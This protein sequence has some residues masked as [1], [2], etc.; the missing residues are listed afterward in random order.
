MSD[1]RELEIRLQ[2]LDEAQEYL[3]TLEAALLGVAHSQ[4]DTEKINGA[5]RAAHSIK[6]GAGMMGYS[7]LN[8]LAHRLEDS[9]KVLKIQKQ[10]LEI[11]PELEQLLLS[12]V[13]CLN[14]VIGLNR[15]Q[16]PVEQAWLENQ[17]EPIFEQLHQRLGDPQEEDAAS[18]LSPEEG[19]DI[20]PML[21]ETEVEGCLQ[22]LEAI[23]ADPQQPCLN[24]E[25]LILAQELQGLGEMLQISAFTAL[26]QSVT[27]QLE[28][29]PEHYGIIAQQAVAAWRQSQALV[30]TGQ[31]GLL[32]VSIA[33]FDASPEL[34]AAEVPLADIA[35]TDVTAD[36]I[37]TWPTTAPIEPPVTAADAAD[38]DFQLSSQATELPD[39][40]VAA[41]VISDASFSIDDEVATPPAQSGRPLEVKPDSSPPE[42]EEQDTNVRVSVKRLNA[43]NDLMGELTIERNSLT[44]NVSR[45]RGLIDKLKQRVQTLDQANSQLRSAYDQ[46][47][48]G[49]RLVEPKRLL[50]AAD[51]Q[52]QPLT[53]AATQQPNGHG[54]TFDTLEMDRYG[55][56][57][58]LSQEMME[59]IVQI[60][61]VTSD[62][63]LELEETEQ[64]GRKFNKTGKQLQ[65]G[66]TQV[67]MRPLSDILERFPRALRDLCLEHNKEVELKVV[68][69]N[70]LVDRNILEN[71]A[72]PLMHLLRNAFDHGLEDPNTRMT[73][74]KSRQGL[75]EIRA[76][77]RQNRTLITVK[78]DGRG[79][80]LDKVRRRAEQMGLDAELL[81]AASHQELLS[82]IFEPGFS[83][84]TEVTDL[85]GRGVG[86]DVVRNNLKQMRGEITVDTEPGQGTTFTLSVPFT[87][88]VAR[89]LLAESRNM[90]LAIPTD[91]MEEILLLPPEA[92]MST[93]QHE[94]FKWGDRLIPL[95]RLSDWLAFNG[96]RPNYKLETPPAI[97]TFTVLVV[98]NGGQCVG[99]QVDRCWGEQEVAIRR[100]EGDLPL[101]AGFSNCTILGDGRVVPLV[102]IPELLRWITSNQRSN[103][104]EPK[105]AV[106]SAYELP[107]SDRRQSGLLPAIASHTRPTLL[108]VDDSINVRRFLALTLEKA[109]YRV[110]QARDGQDAL[111]KLQEGLRPQAVI[112]DIEMPRLDGY[113]FLGKAKA[114]ATF[115]PIPVIMLTSRSGQKHRQIAMNLG[116][117]AY[118]SKPYNEHVLLKTLEQLVN[119]AA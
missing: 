16:L 107:D 111:D 31:M 46:V 30:L 8:R 26:C 112:C 97:D 29:T 113:G 3:G 59:T 60:Q 56:L 76:T 5:L 88:S 108:I 39:F 43:L 80:P 57:H 49:Q 74:G 96:P 78:D 42:E 27:A 75:I 34:S 71:L 98:N 44:L 115:E 18:M 114:D 11:D 63:E 100:V 103:M 109:G 116:A 77:H 37:E 91:V 53:D 101:P 54:N 93:A 19:Q 84:S 28:A 32:P 48:V 1:A 90:A 102:S 99:L 55:D 106:K 41:E 81:A 4:V 14:Q 118:F 66:L 40:S 35:V 2:F 36:N 89:I 110:E 86:M 83:T 61:E 79:I 21:F 20:I 117:N 7:V 47:A 105:L 64:T 73:S 72:D 85:S 82:L 12:G 51:A 22:R 25:V 92:V 58:L 10:Q 94:G 45:L 67:R 87:L 62:V 119:T 13:D 104:A 24:E 50:P 9:F 15:Q 6:G 38:F 95:V 70:T 23:L 52:P 17:V 33:D 65:T 69:G 68:G